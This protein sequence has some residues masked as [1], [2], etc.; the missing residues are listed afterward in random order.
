MRLRLRP[1]LLCVSLSVGLGGAETAGRLTCAGPVKLS[2]TLLPVE[3]IPSW[4]VVRGDTIETLA[5]PAFLVL[6]DRTRIVIAENS[7]VS[8]LGDSAGV[9]V[10][11]LKGE[12]SYKLSAEASTVFFD[13]E[14]ELRSPAAGEAHLKSGNGRVDP[15]NGKQETKPP[16]HERLRS[17]SAPGQ[18]K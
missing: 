11:L 1:A 16:P 4:P 12:L 17:P 13:G 18:N 2:G 5:E 15:P 14:T 9:R 7:R 3:D 10:R 8:L 6:L